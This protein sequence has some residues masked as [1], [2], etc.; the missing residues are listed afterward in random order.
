MNLGYEL[1]KTLMVSCLALLSVTAP[2]YAYAEA[3]HCYDLSSVVE[4]ITPA[5]V[6][7][8]TTQKP[9]E[10]KQ[11]QNMPATPYDLF[12][13]FLEKEFTLPEQM[14]KLTSLGSGF[15]ISDDGYIVTNYHV[16]NGAEEIEVMLAGDAEKN[17]PAKLIGYDQKTDL[18]LLKIDI[19][20]K[21][22][23]L[24]FGDSET[25]K[26]GYP[27]IAVGNP[28]GL[29]GTVTSGIVSAK[30][31]YISGETFDDYIQTDAAINSGN[32]GGPLCDGITGKVLGVNSVIFSPSG[33]NIGIGFAIPASIV[34][35]VIMELKDKGKIIRGW[36]GV[37][38]QP[39][40]DNIA[41]A[42]GL[43]S[44][45]GALVAS[46]VDGSPANKAGLKIGDVILN[47]DGKPINN[48]NKLP[49]I[50]GE[51]PI[52]KTVEME[53]F[54]D[55]KSQKIPLVVAQPEK[56]DPFSKDKEIGDK[57]EKVVLGVGVSNIT[58]ELKR[59]FQID[60]G[61]KGVVVT[62]IDKS[63]ILAFTGIKAGDVIVSIN[64]KQIDNIDDF[65]KSFDELT[66]KGKGSAV[67]LV[68]RRGI[69]RFVGIE[70]K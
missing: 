1:R 15:I 58:E 37:V 46:I 25:T 14:R 17:H 51:T 12:R 63:S 3:T 40:D 57:P 48:T 22:E 54:R 38:I 41:K 30:A 2:V 59:N 44:P 4:K 18:A 64:R 47:F 21:L 7:I 33:G 28:F 45:K 61:I 68:S 55:G 13:E 20:Q 56:D 60:S 35:P 50:V 42:M 24:E 62:D 16:V 8:S 39:I 34:K 6:N 52:N 19:E 10:K 32:S 9:K 70:L 31:R 43:D 11:Q 53:I 29:G 23:Y 5:V 36:L 66:R 49:R 26:V 27:V 65:E 67:L 69:N